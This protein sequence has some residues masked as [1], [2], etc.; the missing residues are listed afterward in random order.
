MAQAK[1]SQ[2]VDLFG[3]PTLTPRQLMQQQLASLM[4]ST[5]EQTKG[6]DPRT[7]GVSMMGSAAGG[8]LNK[9]LIEKGVLPKPPEIKRSGNY[10]ETIF[11]YIHACSPLGFVA[12]AD[13]KGFAR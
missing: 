2:A 4:E 12:V 9:V 5:A 7:R 8:L 13:P 1:Q 11:K 3:N 10:L 6:A